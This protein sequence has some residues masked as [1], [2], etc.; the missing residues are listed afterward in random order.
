MN[1]RKVKMEDLD[2]IT[3]IEAACFAVSEAATRKSLLAVYP[4][5]FWIL[6]ENDEN[7]NKKIVSFVN[8]MVTD[9]PNLTDKMYENPNLHNEKGEWQMIFGVNTLSDYRKKGG[10][11]W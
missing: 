9:S 8:G 1:I 2:E 4:H 7:G 3:A 10:A 5:Y 11:V 6:E